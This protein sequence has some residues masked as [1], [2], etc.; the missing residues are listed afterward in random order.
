MKCASH[1]QHLNMYNV[2][3]Q[4]LAA[5]HI[6]THQM[7]LQM[8]ICKGIFANIYLEIYLPPPYK[9]SAFLVLC[10]YTA[11]CKSENALQHVDRV[12]IFKRYYN[13][14]YNFAKIWCLL[15]LFF[16]MSIDWS[17]SETT[18][19]YTKRQKPIRRK[20][21]HTSLMYQAFP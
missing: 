17:R 13:Q 3:M 7:Y 10:A 4:V 16:V 15:T 11:N 21:T 20:H 2:N 12:Q 8:Y 1:S 9:Y 5:P 6:T 19:S 18:L 14:I